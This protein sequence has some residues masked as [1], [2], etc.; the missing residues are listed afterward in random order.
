MLFQ[1]FVALIKKLW[2]ASD[3][4]E[5]FALDL[6]LG[7]AKED[8]IR[9][10]LSTIGRRSADRN[11]LLCG[12]TTD[13]SLF[14]N[15]TPPFPTASG[16]PHPPTAAADPLDRPSEIYNTAGFDTGLD[17]VQLSGDSIE[18]GCNGSAE[19][20]P[21]G[22]P[23]DPPGVPPDITSSPQQT[24]Q[25]PRKAPL[26]PSGLSEPLENPLGRPLEDPRPTPR[27]LR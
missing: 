25:T 16:T 10:I 24:P 19:K 3:H 13:P 21:S 15:P 5:D 18:P 6:S 22:D 12:G 20:E 17:I 9:Q 27:P 11:E 8:R 14:S 4:P 26:V 1:G 23:L 7:L 2:T